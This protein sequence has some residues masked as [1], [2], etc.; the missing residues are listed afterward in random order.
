MDDRKIVYPKQRELDGVYTRVERNGHWYSVCF[1]DLTDEE[2]DKY[3]ET[4]DE[5]SLKLLS[6]VICGE[7]RSLAD[8]LDAVKE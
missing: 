2:Q 8:Y 5:T 6:K 3:M 4:L 7:L 1:S